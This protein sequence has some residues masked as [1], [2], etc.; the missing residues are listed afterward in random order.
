MK[1]PADLVQVDAEHFLEIVPRQGVDNQKRPDV[2]DLVVFDLD[3]SLRL[4]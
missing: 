3:F 2:C 1:H 4:R